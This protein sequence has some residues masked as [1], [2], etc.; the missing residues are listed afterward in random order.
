MAFEDIARTAFE[1]IAR[2]GQG[3]SA[4]VAGVALIWAVC[5]AL[6]GYSKQNRLARFE[7]YSALSQGWSDD[8]NIREIKSLIEKDPERKLLTL[9]YEKKE[10]YVAVFEEIALMLESG[11]IRE[12]VA[13]YM[14]G[15]Y[16]IS[17]YESEDFWAGMDKDSHYWSLFFR[18]ARKMKK[19]DS[20][21]LAGRDNIEKWSFRF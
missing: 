15:Y 19:I 6:Y 17:C 7:K 10:E 14:F 2:N 12:Q 16:T 3:I 1:G 11:I 18:F 9:D 4:I 21:I 20:D 8:E 13:Y 5:Q